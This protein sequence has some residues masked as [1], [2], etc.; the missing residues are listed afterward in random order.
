MKSGKLLAG[1]LAGLAA[2]IFIGILIAPDKGEETRKKY[3]RKGN[4]YASDL[5]K[6]F[7]DL[8]DEILVK[9]KSEQDHSGENTGA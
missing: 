2:G 4:D 5:K 8:L 6:K 9:S 3:F 1:L 7:N